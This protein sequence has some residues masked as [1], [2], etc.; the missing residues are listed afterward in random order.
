MTCPLDRLTAA[1]ARTGMTR[2]FGR[3]FA[4]YPDLL[5]K[6]QTVEAVGPDRRFKLAGRW[7]T[8]FG[9]DSFLGLDQDPRV[10]ESIERG[11]RGWGS[12][13][14]SSRAFSS[15]E[16]NVRAEG[17]IADWLGTESAL[18]YPSVTLANTGALPGLLT[19]Q[20]VAVA[21][22]FAH[23][24][25]DEGLK[26]AKARGVRTAKFAHNDP[27]DLR[28][29]LAGLRPYRHAV[30]A[31]DGVYSMSGALPPLAEFR[32]VA[33]ENDAVLYVDDAHGTG[34]LGRQGRGTVLGALGDY[35]NTLV[36]GSLSKA[37]SCLG[38]F[39]ACPR[40]V[41]DVLRLRSNPLIFGG[42]VPPAYLEAVCTV[43]DILRSPEYDRLRAKLDA[44]VRH[45]VAGATALGLAVLGGCVPIVS[46]LVGPD[47]A[48]LRAGRFLFE[49]GY[50]VQS[51]VFPAV[52]HG[53]GVLRIQVNACHHPG[54]V[55]GLL[56]ALAALHRAAPLPGP[57]AGVLRFP[58]GVGEAIPA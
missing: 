47:E 45:L 1:L 21:D 50:Y 3:L 16:P 13:N 31:V 54:Q 11:V 35:D 34:V 15:V 25:I 44:N 7:V 12:H 36:V 18:I 53:S 55:D 23:N 8:N 38:G 52:P 26:L 40:A 6:D 19:R 17:K 43:V 58:A 22:Q 48:T 33:A 10:I 39:V 42:P 27:A 41:R 51:V 29:V 14:G 46:V 37:F 5:M 30:V 28:R 56:G 32:R 9:S 49:A 24:S 20:D 57:D 4:D 2:F